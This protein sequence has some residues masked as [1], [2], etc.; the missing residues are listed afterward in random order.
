MGLKENCQEAFCQHSYLVQVSRWRYFKA[1]HPSFDQ[2]GSHNLCG[3]FKEMVTC[4]NLLDYE[5]YETQEVW[6]SQ[7][8][9]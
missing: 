9:L 1:H 4:A 3:L 8:D 5:I 2:E 6:I 7:R